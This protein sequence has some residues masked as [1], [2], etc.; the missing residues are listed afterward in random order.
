MSGLYLCSISTHRELL[1]ETSPC[2]LCLAPAATAVRKQ[3]CSQPCR[4][5]GLPFP[6]K[7]CFKSSLPVSIYCKTV[8]IVH[9]AI[10]ELP[11]AAV[12]AKPVRVR[13]QQLRWRLQVPTLLHAACDCLSL[14][15]T[16]NCFVTAHATQIA[17]FSSARL[18]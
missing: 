12:V 2:W 7:I 16:F 6:R 10:Q 4:Q 8:F 18:K 5:F 9:D 14:V 1:L 13:L 15:T 3:Q 17:C 11:P